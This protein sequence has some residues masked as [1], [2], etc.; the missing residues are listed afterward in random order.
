MILLCKGHGKLDQHESTIL[1]K[2]TRS[3]IMPSAL[4]SLLFLIVSLEENRA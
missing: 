1:S 3:G 2:V 4:L